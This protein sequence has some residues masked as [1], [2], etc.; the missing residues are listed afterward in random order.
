[1][2]VKDFLS[3]TYSGENTTNAQHDYYLKYFYALMLFPTF[4]CKK[5]TAGS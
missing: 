4:K 5:P 3:Q 1:M 2:L